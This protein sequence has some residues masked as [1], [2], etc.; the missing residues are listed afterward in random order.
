MNQYVE[1]KIVLYV[2]SVNTI[3]ICTYDDYLFTFSSVIPLAIY[4]SHKNIAVVER[5]IKLFIVY[6]MV[7]APPLPSCT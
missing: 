1:L 6:V 4:S 5:I 7:I 2:D 3:N